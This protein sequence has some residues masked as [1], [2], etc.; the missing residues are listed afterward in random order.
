[1]DP[2]KGPVF[3][4]ILASKLSRFSVQAGA[5]KE[6]LMSPNGLNIFIMQKLTGVR[7]HC[8]CECGCPHLRR[9]I[10]ALR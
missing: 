10:V 5:W 2:C 8:G 7:C 1:M 9:V 3:F 6:H 4:L